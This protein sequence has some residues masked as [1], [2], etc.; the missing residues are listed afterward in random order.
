MN[1]KQQLL[2]KQAKFKY[3]KQFRRHFQENLILYAAKYIFRNL[4]WM[5]DDNYWTIFVTMLDY[6]REGSN[7]K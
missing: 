5:A 1:L 7:L 3:I 4:S 6:S 2:H